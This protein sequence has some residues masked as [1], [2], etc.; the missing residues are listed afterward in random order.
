[1]FINSISIDQVLNQGVNIPQ[2]NVEESYRYLSKILKLS[3]KEVIYEKFISSSSFPSSYHL[4]GLKDS[5]VIFHYKFEENQTNVRKFVSLISK[6]DPLSW[7]ESISL[8]LGLI[9]HVTRTRIL[10]EIKMKYNH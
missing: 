1:M 8:S 5:F 3:L 6:R 10:A 4:I 2:I 9:N 7:F